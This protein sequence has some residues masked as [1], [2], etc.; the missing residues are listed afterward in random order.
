MP[1]TS[2]KYEINEN[3]EDDGQAAITAIKKN[4]LISWGLQP[5]NMQALRPI[6]DLICTIQNV[7]PPAFNVPAHKYFKKWK[8][9]GSSDLLLNSSVMGNNSFSQDKIKK[10]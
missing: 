6:Q 1:P 5:P 8:P 2:S 3:S 10:G 7:F 4:I 9:I